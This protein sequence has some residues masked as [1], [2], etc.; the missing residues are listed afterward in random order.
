MVISMRC[1]DVS[2]NISLCVQAVRKTAVIYAY[3]VTTISVWIL[4]VNNMKC[5]GAVLKWNFCGAVLK[6]NFCRAVLKWMLRS[7]P[8][9]NIAEP[10]SNEITKLSLKREIMNSHWRTGCSSNS[11]CEFVSNGAG[12]NYSIPLG[13]CAPLLGVCSGLDRTG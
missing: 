6:W 8:Q 13:Q 11:Q 1:F 10:S 3:V 2:W 9:M 5:C 4:Y 7:R 12:V